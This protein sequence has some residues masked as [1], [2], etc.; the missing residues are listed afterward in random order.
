MMLFSSQPGDD[1]L[2]GPTRARVMAAIMTTTL[3]GVFDGTM[4]NIALPSMAQ[5]MQVP[6]SYAVWFANGYLLAAAM[7]LAIFAA[8]AARLGYRPVFLAG[9]TTFTLTSLACALA[10]TPEVLIGMR[11]LQGIGGAATLSIAP[12]ILRSVFPGRLLGRILGLHAL[13]IASSSAIGP[14]LGGTILHTLSWQWLFAINVLPGTLALLLAVKSLP[15]DAVRKQALF[16]TLGAILSALL[17][18]STIVA[19]NSLQDATYHTG[20]LCWTVLA[21]L[22]GM[23]FIWQI[24]R[25][26]NPLL[27]P[28]IFKNERFTLAALTSMIAFVSQGITFIAAALPVSERIRLQSGDFCPAIYAVAARD[29][30]DCAACR[31]VGDTIS[32]PVISTL[33]LMIFVV[34]LILLATLPASP[35]MWD[36]CLR[37]LVCGM[38]FGCFQSPNNREMLSNVSRDYASYASGVLSIMRTFG[39][40]L[41]AAAV[42][43]LLATNERAIHAA[44]WIAAAAS[45]IAVIVSASRLRK[46]THPAETG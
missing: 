29:R 27:P 45:A 38:G 14:V 25:T 5:E 42:G 36:I 31:P 12:A 34:G 7:T 1:G 28:A 40:C 41:G 23:A 22:S 10:K 17:L 8:L 11:V 35:S 46:I 2:P 44:L 39:Q 13:L 43:V 9:L 16:D 6:A 19:A 4:I 20:S 37:S 15:R 32:A 24:R 33:G 21:A 18:G 26:D 30:A 3:M